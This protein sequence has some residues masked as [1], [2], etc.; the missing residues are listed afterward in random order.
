MK[1][2]STIIETTKHQPTEIIKQLG[3]DIEILQLEKRIVDLK[4]ENTKVLLEIE[5][6]KN[7][8]KS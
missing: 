7:D 6:E 4:Y 5:K 2:D 8:G 1:I 3:R